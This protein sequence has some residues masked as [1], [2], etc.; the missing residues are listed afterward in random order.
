MGY[1]YSLTKPFFE[2]GKELER[3]FASDLTRECGG[4][5]RPSSKGDDKYKHIDLYYQSPIE[6]VRECSIDVK[7]A[8]KKSRSDAD[9]TYDA[10]WLE[11]INGEGNVGS[12]CGKEDYLVFEGKDGWYMTRRA[13]LLERTK[14][15]ITDPTIY[16]VNPHEY[17][18]LYQRKGRSDLIVMVPFSFIEENTCKV[19][20]K[21]LDLV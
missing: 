7:G 13:N 15:K 17:F 8:R 21:H 6:G 9:V 14:S 18:K 5:A 4:S 19:I 2:K 10:T 1:D 20:K 16:N 3:A 12:L 11:F